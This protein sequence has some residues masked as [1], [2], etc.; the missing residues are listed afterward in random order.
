VEV[1]VLRCGRH[2][3]GGSE[4]LLHGGTLLSLRRETSTFSPSYPDPP[5]Q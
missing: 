3:L 2:V 4:V 1:L 5:D